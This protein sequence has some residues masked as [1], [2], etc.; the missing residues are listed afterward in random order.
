MERAAAEH[1]FD[2]RTSFVIGD[3]AVDIE[4]GK[5]AGAATVLVRT[6]YGADVER[7]GAV[8]PDYT[9]DDLAAAA[10][11]VAATPFNR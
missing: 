2:P 4:F 3:N 8:H 9:V 7:A 10:R 11:I 5:N 1:G 6:G